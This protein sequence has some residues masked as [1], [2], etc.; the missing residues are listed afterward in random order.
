MQAS[1]TRPDISGANNKVMI[2]LFRNIRSLMKNEE[3]TTNPIKE[4]ILKVANDWNETQQIYSIEDYP[5]TSLSDPLAENCSLLFPAEVLE[6]CSKNNVYDECCKYHGLFPET[7]KYIQKIDMSISEDPEIPDYRH[8]SF[9]LTIADS[10]EH[11]LQY[12]DRFKK[13]LRNSI[14]KEKRQYFVYNY[15]LI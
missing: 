2:V 9:V 8:I 7:F 15:N 14:V 10:I 12:E 6:F 13:K 1:H 5:T 4:D 3:D 11:V